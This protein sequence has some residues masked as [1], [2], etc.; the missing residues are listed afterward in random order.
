MSLYTKF[1]SLFLFFFMSHCLYGMDNDL[2]IIDGTYDT[3]GLKNKLPEKIFVSSLDIQ[4]DF[5]IDKDELLYFIDISPLSHVTV[6]QLEKTLFYLQKKEAFSKIQ[7]Q[8]HP[9]KHSLLFVIEG[10]FIFAYL[11]LHGSVIGKEKFKSCYIMDIGELFDEKKHAYSLKKMK[12]RFYNHGCF[13]ADV[14]DQVVYDSVAKKVFVDLYLDQGEQ[15]LIGKGF[16]DCHFLE[17]V[18]VQDKE[19]IFNDLEKFFVKK[20]HD[21]AYSKELLE[22]FLQQLKRYLH[23]KGYGQSAITYVETIDYERMVVDIHFSITF[24]EKK[25]FIFWGN[26]FFS[27]D[28]FLE[29]ILMYGKSSWKFPGAIVSDEIESMYKAKGFWDV[30]VS[31]KQEPGKIFCMI[32]EGKRAVI[33]SVQVKDNFHIP[34]KVIESSCFHPIQ[35]LFFDK[36]VYDQSL[37]K[38]LSLYKQHGFW[39]IAIIKEE[40][41][42]NYDNKSRDTLDYSVF[43]TIDEGKIHQLSLVQIPQYEELLSQGPFA[44]L[45]NLEKPIPFNYDWIAIQRSWLSNYFKNLGHTKVMLSYEIIG[46]LHEKKIIWHVQLDEKQICFGKIIVSGNS[47]IPFKNLQRELLFG[48]HD[49]WDKKKID[50]SIDRLRNLELFDTAHIYAHKEID[51]Q[52]NIPVGI[53]LIDSEMYEVRARTGI[54]QVGKDFSLQQGFS[55]KFGGTFL[56][57]NPYKF[58]DRFIIEGDCTRFYG[59]FSVQYLMP[60]L[61]SRRSIRSQIKVYSNSYFQP[62]FIGSDTSIYSAYQQGCL[63]GLQEKINAWNLGL[64]VGLEFKGIKSADVEDIAFSLKYNPLFL[65]KKFAYVFTEP[66]VTW[67]NVDNVINP[68]SGSTAM[69]SCLSMVDIAEQMSL[70]KFLVEYAMYVPLFSKVVFAFRTRLGHI[71]NQDYVQIMPIDRFYL[72]GANTIRGYD[73]DYCPPLGLLSQ[74][75]PAENVGLPPAADNLWRYVN[76]GGRTMINTNFEVRFPIYYEFEGALF[77]DTGVLVQDSVD[78]FSNN[79]LGGAGFGFRYNT[80]IGALRFDLAFKLDRKYKDFESPYVWYLTLGQAF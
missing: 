9:E 71:F 37:Q 65:Q 6:Q 27:Q 21:K 20:M 75:V 35:G 46:D 72:G 7:L 50:T 24:E 62:L 60:W 43:L 22:K 32:D 45:Q 3:V 58:G 47:K 31:V 66:S 73:R 17:D 1:L 38:L 61:F 44:D 42:V 76:Q 64:N 56:I 48:E 26:H 12:E 70:F 5:K 77:C 59:N 55:Y 10:N 15:F 18:L 68:R 14:T 8:Y 39:N 57:N 19:I 34:Y 63:F 33:Q 29:N 23:K 4:A 40:F 30:K 16:F 51:E 78:D 2:I 49:L 52:G 28:N 41:V 36:T 25:E 53:H 74:P 80:P 67:M 11:K 54:Q 79:L 13:Q 69:V